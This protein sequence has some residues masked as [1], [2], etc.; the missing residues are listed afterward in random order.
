MDKAMMEQAG[1]RAFYGAQAA[2]A[3]A[4]ASRE[5][6]K[7]EILEARL[8]ELIRKQLA[9]E[10]EKVTEKMIEAAV[11]K[12]PRWLAGKNRVIEAEAI[13]G[14][15]KSLAISLADRRDMLIQLG[16]DR[17]EEFKG[18]LRIVAN[19]QEKQDLAER[20][21]AAAGKAVSKHAFPV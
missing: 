21:R 12:D 16:S 7:F 14:I 2:N 4:Q 18:Q 5:K 8:Y 19:E 11:K 3:E 20:A 17:R 10:G 9:S 15:N 1:L 6:A 13:A